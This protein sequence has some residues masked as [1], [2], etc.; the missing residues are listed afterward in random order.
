MIGEPSTAGAQVVQEDARRTAV[1]LAG[2]VGQDRFVDGIERDEGVAIAAFRRVEHA[3]VALL[4]PDE[5]PQFVELDLGNAQLTHRGVM[6]LG[7]G[8]ADAGAEAHDRIPM[9][10]GQPLSRAD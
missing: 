6:E 1:A 7:A 3:D 10:A 8:G 9:D 2:L 5:S 4:A